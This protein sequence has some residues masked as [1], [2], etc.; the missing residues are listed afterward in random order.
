MPPYRVVAAAPAELAVEPIQHRQRIGGGA[1]PSRRR[2]PSSAACARPRTT[3]SRGRRP[4][5]AAAR[6]WPAPRWAGPGGCAGRPAHGGAPARARQ[7]E[8]LAR[9]PLGGRRSP[10][11]R[12]AKATASRQ[13]AF[14]RRDRSASSGPGVTEADRGVHVVPVAGCPGAQLERLGV[15][16]RS[17]SAERASSSAPAKSPWAIRTRLRRSRSLAG[18]V[19]RERFAEQALRA[20]EVEAGGGELGGL[21]QA[22]RDQPRLP[23]RRAWRASSTGLASGRSASSSA[24]RRVDPGL[25]GIVVS[26][27]ITSRSTSCR[28]L[29]PCASSTSSASRM[30]CSRWSSTFGGGQLDDAGRG[31]RGRRGSEHG[32]GTDRGRRRTR[33][34]QPC[35]R[36]ARAA[37]RVRRRRRSLRARRAAA[38]SRPSAPTEP[39]ARVAPTRAATA[40]SSSGGSSIAP[41]SR[42]SAGCRHRA[43]TRRRGSGGARARCVE[44]LEPALHDVVGR[45]E[46]VGDDGDTP[47][48]DA[49]RSRQPG[50]RAVHAVPHG[51][52][53]RLPGLGGPAQPGCSLA[54]GW[55][56]SCRRRGRRP[57]RRSARIAARSTTSRTASASGWR[58]LP[59]SSRGLST[60]TAA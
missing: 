49:S 6:A 10:V 22:S 46:V 27:S 8:R 12:C 5:R 20:G 56:N 18:L 47:P 32:G 24:A 59:G 16:S 26:A 14:V 11:P 33:V 9:A 57:G 48:G 58:P 15:G 39:S 44:I 23:P 40:A 52:H 55:P 50:Q 3:C 1:R 29:R 60:T 17:A 36:P 42:G 2:A 37:T 30:P 7:R 13:L 25:P 43:T 35:V 38:G 41:R 53:A 54:A 51:L 19:G 34:G 45:V 4:H 28:N 21:H 31:G